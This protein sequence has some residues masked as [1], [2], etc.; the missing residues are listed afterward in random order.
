MENI[1][2]DWY[3]YLTENFKLDRKCYKTADRVVVDC[4]RCE[5]T[6]VIRINHLKAK[7]KQLGF[8]ECSRCRKSDSLIKARKIFKEK[9]GVENPFQL[10]TVKKKIKETLL[11]NLQPLWARDNLKKSNK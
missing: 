7:I 1:D 9:H 8:Y 3:T 10:E 6:Q 5:D 4:P 2:L 11:K